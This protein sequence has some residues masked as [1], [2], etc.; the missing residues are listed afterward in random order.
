MLELLDLDSEWCGGA[1]PFCPVWFR[2][3]LACCHLFRGRACFGSPEPRLLSVVKLE[4]LQR[5]T[6]WLPCLAW[7]YLFVFCFETLSLGTTWLPCHGWM[8]LHITAEQADFKG[9]VWFYEVLWV[10]FTSCLGNTEVPGGLHS[11]CAR[12]WLW[13]GSSLIHASSQNSQIGSCISSKN[14][15]Q[16]NDCAIS[17][18]PLVLAMAR[19]SPRLLGVPQHP[20]PCDCHMCPSSFVCV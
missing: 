17:V 9:K 4:F 13:V 19:H 3:P 5:C 10:F 20:A 18:R 6:G 7:C 11:F 15:F 12:L 2:W 1:V 14:G 16:R 8:L